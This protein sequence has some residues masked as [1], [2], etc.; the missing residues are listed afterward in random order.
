MKKLRYL[1]FLGFLLF[2]SFIAFGK[3]GYC[4]QVE[5][6]SY[7]KNLRNDFNRYRIALNNGDGE[8]AISY[9]HSAFFIYL[10]KE[11]PNDNISREDVKV[12]IISPIL[13]LNRDMKSKGINI[14]YSGGETSNRITY[15]GFM[16]CIIESIIT[17]SNPK[18]NKSD[19]DIGEVICI[20]EDNGEN[21]KFIAKDP[22]ETPLILKHIFPPQIINRIMN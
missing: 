17:I 2:I 19:K 22:T 4:Q 6:Y 13:E 10:E 15:D 5:Y 8:T 7:D 21:W 9:F 11:F 1:T 12:G 14:E 3:N 16:I 20:S 18:N